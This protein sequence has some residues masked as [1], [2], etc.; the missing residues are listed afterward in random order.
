MIIK[1]S[2]PWIPI[3]RG[4]TLGPLIIVW[5]DIDEKV[6]LHESCHVDQWRSE[7][8]S[9]YPKY[10]WHFLCNMLQYR[11]QLSAHGFKAWW[12]LA[13]RAIPYEIEARRAAGQRV[14]P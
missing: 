4:I 2:I 8:I 14:E 10:V 12:M 5:K 7:P 3:F 6:I 1:L 13:Y 11:S 9:F